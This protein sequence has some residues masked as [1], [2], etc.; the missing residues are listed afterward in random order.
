MSG[1]DMIS[2]GGDQKYKNNIAKWEGKLENPPLSQN[3]LLR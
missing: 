2:E 3:F 1:V